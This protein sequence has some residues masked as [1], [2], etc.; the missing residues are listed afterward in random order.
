MKIYLADP[1]AKTFSIFV[2]SKN[3]SPENFTDELWKLFPMQ[4]GI[5]SG[6]HRA[7]AEIVPQEEI[8]NEGISTKDYPNIMKVVYKIPANW[9]PADPL[10]II[11]PNFSSL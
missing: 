9:N 1:Q 11:N 6:L 10:L 8:D 2:Y 3:S 5:Q 4:L 7:A